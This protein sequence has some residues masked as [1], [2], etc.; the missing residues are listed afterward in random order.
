MSGGRRQLWIVR[1]I[2]ERV[3][4]QREIMESRLKIQDFA[5]A[6]SDCFW[7]MDESLKKGIVSSSLESDFPPLVA[8]VLTPDTDGRPPKKLSAE[9][10]NELRRHLTQRERFWIRLDLET[11]PGKVL[12]L[13]ISGKP[14]FDLE[15]HF[16]GYRGTGRDITREVTAREAAQLAERR[17]IE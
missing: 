9:S 6:S 14:V 10:W 16:R 11:E 4:T 17:L 2:S 5:E 7:E 1:D 12:W 3:R 13:S 8:S 15:G